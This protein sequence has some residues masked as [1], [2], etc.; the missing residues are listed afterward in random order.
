[1]VISPELSAYRCI[2]AYTP[3]RHRDANPVFIA[4]LPP[5]PT[6]RVLVLAAPCG[7]AASPDDHHIVSHSFVAL[8]RIRQLPVAVTPLLLRLFVEAQLSLTSH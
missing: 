3:D 7:A 8:H 5:K 6:T 2:V 1:M 4:C